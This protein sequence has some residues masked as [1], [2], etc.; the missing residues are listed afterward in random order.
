MNIGEQSKV[1]HYSWHKSASIVQH[2]VVPYTSGFQS[3]VLQGAGQQIMLQIQRSQVPTMIKN[4]QAR[5][6]VRNSSASD[7]QLVSVC[8]WFDKF[9]WW[10]GTRNHFSRSY[11]GLNYALNYMNASRN[12]MRCK[13]KLDNLVPL[14]NNYM[15]TQSIPGSA[16]QF[17]YF[18]VTTPEL[19]LLQLDPR[20]I[21]GDLYLRLDP[22]NTGI[23]V[24]SSDNTNIVLEQID[25]VYETMRLTDADNAYSLEHWKEPVGHPCLYPYE[26]KDTATIAA[27]SQ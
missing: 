24:S 8:K 4:V 6:R 16:T 22:A 21:N 19:E 18:N 11:S 10:H 25:L 15:L 20:F 7:I 13:Q 17:Y 23:C 9:E 14:D 27:S 2:C 3:T 26:L 12:T 1:P 5:L